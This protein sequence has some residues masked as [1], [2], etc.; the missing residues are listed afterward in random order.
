[1]SPRHLV[2]RQRGDRS[3]RAGDVA[4]RRGPSPRRGGRGGRRRPH[5]VRDLRAGRRR[6]S[7]R[8]TST[9]TRRASSCWTAS[10]WSRPRRARTAC[11]PAT[12]GC[13]RSACRTRW[14]SESDRGALGRDGRRRSRA[15]ATTATPSSWR[16]RCRDGDPIAGRRPRPADAVVRPHRARRTWTSA[17][18]R[19]TCWRSRPACAP[20]CSSTAASRVKMMVDT[21]L[22]AQ[23]LHDVHGAVRAGGVRRAARPPVR[24]DVPDPGG[25]GRRRR[26]TASR[27]TS[28]PG[29]VAWAGVGCV[30]SFSNP[31]P[32]PS[33]GSR[34]RRRSRRRGT[35][36]G[37]RGTGSTC[38][39][40]SAEAHGGGRNDGR[41]R[42]GDRR[43]D[44][45]PRHEPSPATTSSAGAGS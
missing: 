37:S 13:S 18:R 31:G 40:A 19:R 43:G 33:G 35:R 27:T 29:D 44:R 3:P 17:S 20:R 30:H 16:R 36:T 5:G 25:R 38:A 11:A 12:T 24:G 23:L 34:R 21:D 39:R 14:R 45:G 26:S 7:R 10:R 2:R 28:R 32:G 8:R 41:P 6:P 22:G 1:M 4:G 15:R 9:A 42:R